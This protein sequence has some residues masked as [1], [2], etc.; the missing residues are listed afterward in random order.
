MLQRSWTSIVAGTIGVFLVAAN[1]AVAQQ[2]SL[3]V[4][5]D[6][7]GGETIYNYGSAEDNSWGCSHWGYSTTARLYSPS[8]RNSSGTAGGLAAS[9]ALSFADDS[10]NWS[11]VTQG[12]YNCSCIYGQQAAFGGG[13]GFSAGRFYGR[14]WNYGVLCPDGQKNAYLADSCSHQCMTAQACS[15]A[16][17]PYLWDVGVNLSVAGWGVCWHNYQGSNSRGL[18]VGP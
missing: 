8:G 7:S 2:M 16:N 9:T 6:V 5:N 1:A 10:G 12:V 15:W 4:Y 11:G 13:M 18:C 14:Y 3:A 17:A